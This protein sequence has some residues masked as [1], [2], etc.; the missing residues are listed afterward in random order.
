MSTSFPQLPIFIPPPPAVL[1][2]PI[3][4]DHIPTRAT[5]GSAGFDLKASFPSQ[6]SITL[7]P[8]ERSL[9]SAGIK[10]AIN[11][12]Y[13]GRI[14][15]RSGLAIRYGIDVLAGV[16]DSDYRGEVGV[17]LVNHGNQDFII[18][19]KDRIAQLIIEKIYEGE[20]GVVNSLSETQR[21]E[22]GFGSSG[23]NT[24]PKQSEPSA[25]SEAF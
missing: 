12:G 14:A 9:I 18:N 8:G 17:M 7:R 20:L 5:P 19:D 24:S 15:P 10:I 1:V 6:P 23:I 16:I 21:G 2:H 11:P 22:G 3:S 25:Y 4:P 13:Y